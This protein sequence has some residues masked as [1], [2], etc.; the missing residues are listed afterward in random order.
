MTSRAERQAKCAVINASFD[1]VAKIPF[2]KD[3][4][5]TS[6]AWFE[7]IKKEITNHVINA[8]DV[9][10]FISFLLKSGKIIENSEF[11]NMQ[12]YYCRSRSIKL[13]NSPTR[14]RKIIVFTVSSDVFNLHTRER[15]E[16]FVS[17]SIRYLMI[18]MFIFY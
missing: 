9:K 5:I 12:G 1:E 2:V 18:L 13:S 8:L 10:Q 3:K 17:P 6:K 14:K 15:K 4:W 11:V 16:V 7:L